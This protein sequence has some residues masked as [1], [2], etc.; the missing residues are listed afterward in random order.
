MNVEKYYY[1][2]SMY[3]DY[4]IVFLRTVRELFKNFWWGGAEGQPDFQNVNQP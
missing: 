1:Q 2:N 3:V 4:V